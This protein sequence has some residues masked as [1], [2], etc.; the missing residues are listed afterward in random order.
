M[1]FEGPRRSGQALAAQLTEEI[2]QSRHF[3]IIERE[4]IETVMKEH[5]FNLSGAVDPSTAKRLGRMLGVDCLIF[6]QV[7]GYR[8]KEKRWQEHVKKKV[9]TGKYDYD[10]YGNKIKVYK[11]VMVPE[12]HLVKNALVAAE[13]KVVDVET[14][15]IVAVKTQTR[16]WKK[17]AVGNEIGALP[18]GEAILQ[19]LSR[20]VA[21]AF[22]RQITPH[23]QTVTRTF[24]RGD[25]RTADAIKYAQGGMW[26]KA[27]QLMSQVAA[28][29]PA[30]PSAHYNLGIAYEGLGQYDLALAEYEKAAGMDP[31]DR[32]MDAAVFLRQ[33]QKERA[34][35]EKQLR[36]RE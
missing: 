21:V 10:D 18:E 23:R 8:V 7:T 24:E 3:D 19:K 32:Y 26:D 13:F 28:D 25:K 20:Q 12:D 33:I 36:G 14:G 1:E 30:S 22:S 17:K 5:S 27:L 31:K 6:G 29:M 34:M 11:E 4:K 15:R 16:T 35:L 9:W 2:F